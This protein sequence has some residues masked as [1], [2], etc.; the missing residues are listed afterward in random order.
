[1]P[2]QLSSTKKATIVSICVAFF[3]T[4]IKLFVGILSG[5]VAVLASAV[6]SLLDM[7]V[8]L[9]NSFA[10][11]K[12]EQPANAHFNY[13]KIKIEAIAS[14]LEGIIITLSGIYL[15]Y[16][17]IEK[18][19][20]NTKSTY[21]GLSLVIILISVFVTLALVLYLRKIAKQTNNMI[22]KADALHYRTD[23]YT[24]IAVLVSLILVKVTHYERLDGIVGAALAIYIIYSS[25]SLIA[26]GVLVLLDR[27][28]DEKLLK[29]IEDII[30]EKKK[31]TAFHQIKS[32]TA[33]NDIFLEVHL[34]FNCAMSLLEAHSISDEVSAEIEDLDNSRR[35]I[36]LVHQ[37]PYDDQSEH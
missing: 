16:E 31:I 25:Y 34:V 24:N 35:W 9:F 15:L 22:I 7:L 6:D 26:E 3:L 12:A 17:G 36:I 11:T 1:M 18:Y 4:I 23:L 32:R 19:I 8:S 30:K 2:K 37:D 10:I 29:Q 13:G 21:L 20:N 28:I 14:V 27:A 33:G 5:S